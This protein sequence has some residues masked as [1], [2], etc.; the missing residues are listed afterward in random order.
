[1]FGVFDSV[2]LVMRLREPVKSPSHGN[3]KAPQETKSEHVNESTIVRASTNNTNTQSHNSMPTT[4]HVLDEKTDNA[5]GV[6]RD[7]HSHCNHHHNGKLEPTTQQASERSSSVAAPT[8]D[9]TTAHT[10]RTIQIKVADHLSPLCRPESFARKDNGDPHRHRHRLM[11]RVVND[12]GLD[13]DF[14]VRELNAK[15]LKQL[16]QMI[17]EHYYDNEI[18]RLMNKQN[19]TLQYCVQYLP[20][21]EY[22]AVIE[23]KG[24]RRAPILMICVNTAQYMSLNDRVNNG[25]RVTCRLENCIVDV[26][27]EL[28]HL[29]VFMCLDN[30]VLSNELAHKGLFEHG[31]KVMYG[32]T[33]TYY[34][35]IP[36]ESTNTKKAR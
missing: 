20:K 17:D 34:E 25:V 4:K 31:N 33:T 22:S 5:Q 21:K 3:A 19:V 16:V 14:D 28:W 15:K 32:H 18:Q 26:L 13:A 23:Y 24:E 36:D 9:S 1:M 27:H 2:R 8:A 29:V 12:L 6:D 7:D 30:Y 35:D 10:N 11:K